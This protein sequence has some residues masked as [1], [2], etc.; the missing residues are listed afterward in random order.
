M[1]LQQIRAH[2]AVLGSMLLVSACTLENDPQQDLSSPIATSVQALTWGGEYRLVPD[3]G[4]PGDQFGISVAADGDTLLVGAYGDDDL[5]LGAG[6]VY[7][8]TRTGD[9]WVQSQKLFASNGADADNFGYAVALQG[10]TALIGA[11]GHLDVSG[12]A[13]TVYEFRRS[14]DTWIEQQQLVPS[15]LAVGGAQEFGFSLALDGDSAVIGAFRGGLNLNQ[16]NAGAAYVFT[17]S[18]GV[19]S[20]EQKLVPSDGGDA[21]EFGRTVALSGDSIVVG[22]PADDDRGIDSGSAYVFTRSDGIWSEEQKLQ[23]SVALAIAQNNLGTSVAIQSDTALI[24]ARKGTPLAPETGSA[25]VYTRNQGVWSQVQQISP[26]E[27]AARN[28]GSS[29]SLRGD[30]VLIGATHDA[31]DGSGAAYIYNLTGDVWTEQ[32]KLV[33]SMGTPGE[34]FG[35][36]VSLADAFCVIGAFVANT[37]GM[38]SGEASVYSAVPDDSS[39]GG[40]AAILDDAAPFADASCVSGAGCVGAMGGGGGTGGSGGTGSTNSPCDGGCI[41]AGAPAS[42]TVQLAGCSCRLTGRSD[43]ALVWLVLAAVCG[44]LGLRR[45]RALCF[46]PDSC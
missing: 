8:F 38:L 15:D 40:S 28:F 31:A 13:G 16:Q 12:Y 29:L 34:G 25:Y 39:L 32:Q 30:T 4:A 11:F 21:D 10:D 9:T 37:S 20:E 41:D 45:A 19:W 3:D 36:S 43:P 24:G 22:S 14:G 44:V 26:S 23:I 17:R 2:L 1:P 33:P 46:E 6:A 35:Q 5:G 42:G 7:V 18:G 27:A